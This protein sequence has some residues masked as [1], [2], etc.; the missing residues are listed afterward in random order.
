[1]AHSFALSLDHMQSIVL[2]AI[3]LGVCVIIIIICCIRTDRKNTT[4]RTKDLLR[5]DISYSVSFPRIADI[6]DLSSKLKSNKEF[7]EFKASY[8]L[9]ISLINSS[10]SI[11]CFFAYESTHCA[12]SII[13]YRQN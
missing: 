7:G 9:R 2:L 1:M 10:D 5:C 13:Q 4:K 12:L 6:I 3:R 11:G 8:N